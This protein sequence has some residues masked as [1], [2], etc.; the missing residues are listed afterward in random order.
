MIVTRWLSTTDACGH[1]CSITIWVIAFEPATVHGL[2]WLGRAGTAT[3]TV[4]FGAILI[5]LGAIVVVVTGGDAPVSHPARRSAMRSAP[6]AVG[7]LRPN[8]GR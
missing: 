6:A 1:T 7:R 5:A 8:A 4:A 2:N 3:V